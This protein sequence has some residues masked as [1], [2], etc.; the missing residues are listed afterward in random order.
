MNHRW[1]GNVRELRNA[2]EHAFVTV[3]GDTIKLSDFPPELRVPAPAAAAAPEEPVAPERKKI[4]DALR[5]ADGH[6]GKAA[7]LLG[8]S[9]VTL[10][11]N[12]RR[13]GL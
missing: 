2:M 5:R 12:M 1:P 7:K 4:E 10:W 13:L 6:R 11:K 9:R 8:C 3:T